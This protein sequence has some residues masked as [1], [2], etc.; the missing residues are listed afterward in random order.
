MKYKVKPTEII[1]ALCVCIL[2]VLTMVFPEETAASTVNSIDVCVNSIIPSMF[3]FMVITSYIQS[4]G[5]YRIIFRPIMPVLRRMIHADDDV[6]SIFMLSLVG[7]Y[8]VG[9]K[10]LKE[11]IAQNNNFPAIIDNTGKAA[12][13]CYCI[14]PSFAVIMI[15]SGVFGS[16]EAGFII[17]LSN[18]LANL[19]AAVIITRIN[20]LRSGIRSEQK[21]DG[22]ITGAVNSASKS[23]FTICTVIVAFN[24]AL[25]CI[26]EA[27]SGFDVFVPEL[28]SGVLEISNMLKITEPSVSLIPFVSAV[29]SFGGICVMLQCAAIGGRILH[30][31]PFITARFFCA[32]LSG[33]YT[34]LFLQFTD[35][36]VCVSTISRNYSYEFS[37]NTVIVPVLTAM[38]III[39]YKSNKLFKKV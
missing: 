29:A 4:S 5:I 33:L 21:S 3:V 6:L 14:S 12:M 19:T 10:L 7:G 35:I 13:F 25:A 36:S 11:S 23:L 16:T 9:I 15:G 34:Y 30:I 27:L 1:K 20:D 2:A 24:V 38:C 26:F 18:I 8:P 17:Y 32:L 39:F 31:K 37:A 22:C 28:V